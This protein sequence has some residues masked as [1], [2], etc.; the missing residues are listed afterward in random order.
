MNPFSF[1]FDCHYNRLHESVISSLH[2]MFHGITQ[3][4]TVCVP[5]PVFLE[6]SVQTEFGKLF[7]HRALLLDLVIGR[8]PDQEKNTG[9]K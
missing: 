9:R 8:P 4:N 5:F 7:K 6:F 2:C 1:G 3:N